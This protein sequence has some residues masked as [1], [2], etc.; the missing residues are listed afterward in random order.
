MVQE[1]D[2]SDDDD[3]PKRGG[4]R[5]LRD[6]DCPDCSANNPCDEKV[7]EKGVELRCNYCSNEYRITVGDDG[8]LK[9]KEI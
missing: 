3:G 8:K 1:Y 7:S 5:A 9:F 4:G 2:S 6:W